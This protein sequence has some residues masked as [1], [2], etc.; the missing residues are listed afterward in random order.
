MLRSPSELF[1]L[2]FVSTEKFQIN[3]VNPILGICCNAVGGPVL[4]WPLFPYS[5]VSGYV[6]S[7]TLDNIL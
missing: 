6:V 4:P 1:P 5:H 7:S 2:T 3:N